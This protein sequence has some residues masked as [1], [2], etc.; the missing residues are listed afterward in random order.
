MAISDR[1]ARVHSPVW[2]R[3]LVFDE[4]G[5]I[6]ALVS[7]CGLLCV[8]AGDQFVQPR[9]L[10]QVARQASS[11]GIMAVGMPGPRRNCARQ[12]LVTCMTSIWYARPPIVS[13]KR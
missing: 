1:T 10:L 9:N 5:V 4:I 6:V 11:Y 7:V 8:A 12:R 3:L 13:S 2:R